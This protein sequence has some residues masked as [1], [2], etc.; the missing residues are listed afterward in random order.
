MWKKNN[1]YYY[2]KNK[3]EELKHRGLQENGFVFICN[4]LIF[5]LRITKI[6][7]ITKLIPGLY[8]FPKC[9]GQREWKTVSLMND[10]ANTEYVCL[11]CIFF[12][13]FLVIA[14]YLYR[15]VFALKLSKILKYKP[16][17]P[18]H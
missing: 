2:I 12:Y 9:F 11:Y 13:V 7:W 6:V 15:F 4:K 3:T 17:Q 18:Y 10:V 1:N 5:I 16:E 14:F 8:L